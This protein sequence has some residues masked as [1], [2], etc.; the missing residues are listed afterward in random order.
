MAA[1]AHGWLTDGEQRAWR[2][3]LEAD[4]ILLN[5]LERQLQA[6]SGLSHTDYEILVRLSE[7]PERTIRMAELADQAL[8]SRSRLS[9]AIARLEAMDWVERRSCPTD[10]RGTL[11]HMTDAGF[12]AIEAAAPGHVE[13][14][15]RFVFDTLT[16][17]QV[18]QLEAIGDAIRTAVEAQIGSLG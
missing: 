18:A 9:H 2:A 16:D 11:A 3:F 1:P 4:R 12:A 13:A 8:L 5:G 6:E 15:R 17:E 10:K 14:V 7:A